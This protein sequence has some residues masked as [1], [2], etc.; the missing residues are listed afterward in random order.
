MKL[1][2]TKWIAP[3]LL[4]ATLV[5][6]NDWTTPELEN[7]EDYPLT[8]P[9]KPESYYE[10]LRAY[11]KTKHEISFGWYAGWGD[12]GTSTANMLM[13]V[14]DSMD[15]ISLWGSWGNL[16]EGKMKDLKFVQEK[17]GTKVMFCSF[18]SV[19]GQNMTPPKYD[20]DEDTRE[21]FWGWVDGDETA[22]EQ[23]IRK[24]ARAFIDSIDKYGY[25]GLDIDYEPSY[26]YGGKLANS[27]K[28]MAYLIDELGKYIGP[29][30]PNPDR[31]FIFDGE[32]WAVDPSVVDRITYLVGQAY[33]VSGGK[34]DPNAGQSESN[35]EYRLNQIINAYRGVMSEEEITNKFVVTENL[36]SAV[37]A[38]N[39]GYYWTKEEG[40][41]QDKAVC[42]SLL[43]MAEW[44][45]NNGY[46]KGGFGAYQFQN[47][48]VNTPAYKWMRKGIQACN[49]VK[50]DVSTQVGF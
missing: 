19:V 25:N 9:A 39:G 31:W 7:F 47:E 13:S 3:F 17:K 15:V 22:I 45:P 30:S 38:L 12:P 8:E 26:G 4:G 29:K 6:C 28:Y 36:E 46:M 18:T 1:D 43:G 23:S 35:M 33:S 20:V 48:K 34:P 14:P 44:K 40:G 37:D 42:P 24:Y 21:E 41:R 11:K 5:G 27:K 32:I 2:I 50:A 49:P 10:A 16:S